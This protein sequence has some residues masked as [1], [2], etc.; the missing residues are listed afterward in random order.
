MHLP[1][2]INGIVVC[3]VFRKDAWSHLLLAEYLRVG[4]KKAGFRGRPPGLNLSSATG[5]PDECPNV[6]LPSVL[7]VHICEM[8]V[9]IRLM[10]QMRRVSDGLQ[11]ARPL[12]R[13]TY[14]LAHVISKPGFG[15][16][17]PL[18]GISECT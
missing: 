16:C 6:S 2:G 1:V 15:S 8:G 5:R 12:V 7:S 11:S 10:V 17:W 13:A 3:S 4:L 9:V 18:H 14:T